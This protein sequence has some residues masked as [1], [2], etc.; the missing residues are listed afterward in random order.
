MH[1]TVVY[2]ISYLQLTFARPSSSQHPSSH[3]PQ[4]E[5]FCRFLQSGLLAAPASGTAGPVPLPPY[6]LLP[7]AIPILLTLWHNSAVKLLKKCTFSGDSAL[8]TEKLDDRVAKNIIICVQ[9][10][11]LGIGGLFSPFVIS[12]FIRSSGFFSIGNS[13]C[14][15]SGI[16][17][18]ELAACDPGEPVIVPN[19][20]NSD[21]S[22]NGGG[23]VRLEACRTA[24]DGNAH[25][26]GAART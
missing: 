6:C 8:G 24:C 23:C 17:R 1:A 21:E 15:A 20:G 18:G 25:I 11:L 9:I 22:K 12:P 26:G 14:F 5:T 2:T 10:L 13:S 7:S 19:A 16:L 4:P 3:S